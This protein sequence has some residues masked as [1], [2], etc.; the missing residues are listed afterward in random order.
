MYFLYSTCKLLILFAWLILWLILLIFIFFNLA[1]HSVWRKWI[2]AF[3]GIGYIF[4]HLSSLCQGNQSCLKAIFYIFC[5]FFLRSVTMT[6]SVD[7]FYSLNCFLFSSHKLACWQTQCFTISWTDFT[8]QRWPPCHLSW[9][10]WLFTLTCTV[11]NFCELLKEYFLTHQHNFL[12]IIFILLSEN[13]V[14]VISRI[15]L[16]ITNLEVANCWWRHD[17]VTWYQGWLG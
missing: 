8:G 13:R 1:V 14:W 6:L 4:F 17:L 3:L 9:Y 15:S 7:C 5:L 10:T 2:L 12:N 16:A 11:L